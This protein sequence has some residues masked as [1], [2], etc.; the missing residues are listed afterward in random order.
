MSRAQ[1]CSERTLN[2]GIAPANSKEYEVSPLAQIGA[3]RQ[4]VVSPPPL[5][6]DT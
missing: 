2:I 1:P 3:K 4:G 5:Y 6:T